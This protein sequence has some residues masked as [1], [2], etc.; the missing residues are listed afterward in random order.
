MDW[1]DIRRQKS[2]EK[3]KSNPDIT[4]TKL[5]S[6][7]NEDQLKEAE[8]NLTRYIDLAARIY[9]RI[10]NDPKVLARLKSL[11]D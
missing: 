3:P 10:E 1:Q 5:F 11:I 2:E 4:L 6:G 7:L 8:E 9:R